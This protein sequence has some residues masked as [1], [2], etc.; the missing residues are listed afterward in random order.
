MNPNLTM[1]THRITQF[2]IAAISALAIQAPAE[3]A[4]KPHRI[5]DQQPETMANVGQITVYLN[6]NDPFD[7]NVV[8][9]DKNDGNKIIF[10]GKIPAHVR[11]P[12]PCAL[13]DSGYGNIATSEDGK[14]Y[15]GRSFLKDN[16]EITL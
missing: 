6:N 9:I 16:Q 4:Y 3:T 13:N 12:I 2:F 11:M 1:K 7:N 14:P 5:S 15:I 8:V 10:Q